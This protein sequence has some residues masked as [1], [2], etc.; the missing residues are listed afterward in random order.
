MERTLDY[1]PRFDER[2]RSFPVTAAPTW[3]V[4]RHWLPG[5]TLD[6]LNEGACVGHAVV[7]V[8]ESTPKRSKLPAAQDGAFGIYKLAQFIDEWE[9][10]AYEGT[11]VLAGAKVAHK[12]GLVKSYRWCFGIDDVLQ[13]VLTQGP[14]VIGIEW[15]DSMFKPRPSGLLD[16]SGRAAGG[17]ALYVYGVSLNRSLRGENTKGFVK[18]R[19]SWG[20]SYGVT[21]GSCY[22][23]IEDLDTLLSLGGE[24]CILDQ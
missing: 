19:N 7:G 8:L 15:R 14:V 3:R 5:K 12:T 1:I 21:K 17:H 16:I 11:S 24:A 22:M 9:G 13:T 18:L 2:S 20:E 4:N 23:R 6:Q 10:E